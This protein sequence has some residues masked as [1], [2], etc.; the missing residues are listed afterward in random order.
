MI[1]GCLQVSF[2]RGNRHFF[3]VSVV[4]PSW[5]S[6]WFSLAAGGWVFRLP[7]THSSSPSLQS[8]V[9]W[10]PAAESCANNTLSSL[11]ECRCNRYRFCLSCTPPAGATGREA[12]IMGPRK[13][14]RVTRMQ[15][16]RGLQR[17]AQSRGLVWR[18]Q[19][20]ALERH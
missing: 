1:S 20:C 16:W 5:L 12:V 19:N 8:G 6:D 10:L 2:Q 9:A 4:S 14:I 3:I 11:Y 18:G 13:W 15:S 7:G 17:I